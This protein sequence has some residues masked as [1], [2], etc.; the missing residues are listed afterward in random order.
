M[1]KV[2]DITGLRFGRLVVLSRKGGAPNG[3]RWTCLC[4]CGAEH[5][6]LGSALVRGTTK[7][8][9]CFNRDAARSR[10]RHGCARRGRE[11]AEYRAWRHAR[12]R[13]TNPNGA[14]WENYGGRGIRNEFS[15][16]EGF[17]AEAG[18]RPTPQHSIDR[19]DNDDS[20]RPGNVRWATKLDQNRNQRRRHGRH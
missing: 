8:C 9:G 1:G 17:L 18:P 12:Q 13:T 14:D 11:T 20:Y 7:S 15:S 3:M 10:A 5:T 6:V 19:I 4:D 2:I 16:F